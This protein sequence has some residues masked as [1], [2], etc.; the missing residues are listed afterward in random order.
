MWTGTSAL[1]FKQLTFAD[2]FSLIC[3]SMRN[4]VLIGILVALCGGCKS[5]KKEEPVV[6]KPPARRVTA[7]SLPGRGEKGAVRPVE[8]VRGR[9]IAVREPLRFVVVDFG[10][11]K[12]P[13]LEQMLFVYRLDQKVAELKVSGPYLGTTVAAD[14]TAGEVREG[15]L[16]REQ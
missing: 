13:K 3:S 9:I 11:T 15:D 4:I 2:W 10:A 1:R 8:A 5:A 12:M 7:E 16:V 14:I 6:E